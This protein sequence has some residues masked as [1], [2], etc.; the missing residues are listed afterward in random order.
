MSGEQHAFELL[1]KRGYRVLERN[2]RNKLGEIDI[3]ARHH[4]VICFIEVK[5]R[6]NLQYGYPQEAITFDKQRRLRRVALTYLKA[7]NALNKPARF[8]IVSIIHNDEQGKEQTSIIENAFLV[9]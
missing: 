7:H 1:E 4:G 8:D 9:H 3:I 5:T 2:Y 6:Q